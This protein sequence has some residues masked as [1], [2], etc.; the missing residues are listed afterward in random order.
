[1]QWYGMMQWSRVEWCNGAVQ[2]C[3]AVQC[4]GVKWCDGAVVPGSGAVLSVAVVPGSGAMQRCSGAVQGCIAVPP[5]QSH[6]QST[7]K[8][9]SR[10]RRVRRCGRSRRRCCPLFFFVPSF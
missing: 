8:F 3:D 7:P 4:C 9:C 5:T 6:F 2:W 10:R 1:M